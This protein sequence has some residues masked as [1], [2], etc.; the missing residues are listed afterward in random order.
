M[1]I[2]LKPQHLARYREIARL[3]MKYG[4]SDL[5]KS[6]GLEDALAEENAVAAEIGAPQAAQL[7]DDLER[8]GPT[9][10]KL[11]QLLSTR[12]DILP[13]P[14]TRALARL[15]DNVA[16]FPYEDVEEIVTSELGVRISKAFGSFERAPM[17]AASLGQVHRATLRDGRHIAVKVQRPHIRAQIVDDLDALS[18]VAELLDAHTLMG[19]RFQLS[20]MLQEFRKSL[21]RELDYRQEA[22]NLTTLRTNLAEFEHIVVPA[23][24][25][26][27]STSRVLTMEYVHG[28]KVTTLSPVVRLELHGSALADELFRAY[29]KQTLVDGFFH[30]DPHPGNVY[31]TD[32]GRLALIDLGMVA[33][34]NPALQD[35]L[36]RLLLAIG[37]GR[38]E[39]A[40]E[41]A[42]AIGE[43]TEDFDETEFRRRVTDFV[44]RNQGLT[45]G[46]I[47]VGTNVMEIAKIS[48]DCG[49][50]VPSDLTMLGKAL[51]NLDLVGRTLDPEFDPNDAIRRHA[52]EILRERV[53]KSMSPG[54]MFSSLIEMKDFVERF[55][56]R[57]NKIFDHVAN[58]DLKITV[59]AFDELRLMEGLQKIANRITVGLILAALIVGASMLMRV[60][61]DFRLF[62]YPGFAIL[63]FLAA[64]GGG[65]V[66]MLNILFYDVSSRR[67][68]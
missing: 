50:R 43:Q 55:P 30:A 28:V 62:G 21:M 42:M 61:T 20:S 2:S 37:D 8:M 4:R 15:Q 32:D 9:F 18:E 33:H 40:A 38:S 68:G 26:D 47:Q 24:I 13:L 57:A 56:G 31:I 34:L 11:G 53:I 35:K 12:S 41:L 64:A 54:A 52:A 66:L 48:S 23:P 45:A 10:I 14:Y 5:V 7:A 49:V 3:L 58:N 59:D 17:A 22:Q 6:A 63:F 36:L 1:G 51:L 60:D 29:L 44:G 39:Q 19:R 46:E 67:R 65:V 27:Y 25:D 16:P